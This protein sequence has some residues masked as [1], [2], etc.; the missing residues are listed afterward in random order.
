M[1][2]NAPTE[3]Q[4]QRDLFRWAQLARGRYPELQLM[5][6]IPNEGRRSTITGARMKAEGMKPGVPDI[7]LPVARGPYHALY[8]E[9]KRTRA[10]RVSEDQRAWLAKLMRVGNKAIVCRG[11]DA[12]RA[13]IIEYLEME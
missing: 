4:E 12:A 1:P 6:H 2:I 13:A 8:I 11:W 10:S 9:M 7:C 5:Y 3:A